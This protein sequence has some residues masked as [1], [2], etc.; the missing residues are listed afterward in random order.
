MQGIALDKSMTWLVFRDLKNVCGNY[1]QIKTN[2]L[3]NF[4]VFKSKPLQLPL[5]LLTQLAELFD[6]IH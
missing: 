3:L 1:I 4:L 2:H 6:K 5:I